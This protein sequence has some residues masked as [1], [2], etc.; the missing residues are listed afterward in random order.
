MG[1]MIAAPSFNKLDK[2]CP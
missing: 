2:N 1:E